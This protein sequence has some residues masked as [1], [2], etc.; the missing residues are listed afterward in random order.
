MSPRN[1]FTLALVALVVFSMAVL[2][3][4]AQEVFS[5]ISGRVVDPSGGVLA[6]V[7][8][9]A[10]NLDTNQETRTAS[11]D[12][13]LYVL[14]N[15]P[16]GRYA[17]AASLSGFK[18]F[19]QEGV[20]LNINQRVT[21]D[22]T[23]P[24]GEVSETITVS[25]DAPL[26]QQEE[27]TISTIFTREKL[28]RLPVTR[29]SAYSLQL[30]APG[31]VSSNQVPLDAD[32]AILVGTTVGNKYNINGARQQSSEVLLDGVSVVHR[33]SGGNGAAV[34]PM[35]D[36]VEE[37][38]IETH[39][40]SAEFGNLG[41]GALQATVRSGTNKFHGTASW[42]H[43]NDNLN[44]RAFNELTKG[45]QKQNVYNGTIG[46][47]ILRNS[48]FFFFSLEGFE[49][50]RQIAR[51]TTVP[52][53][54]Q[55]GGDFSSLVDSR[56]NP[57]RIYDPLTTRTDPATGRVIRDPFPG[58]IIQAS[59]ISPVAKNLLAFYPKPNLSG[60]RNNLAVNGAQATPGK[61]YHFKVDKQITEKNRLFVRYSH[62]EVDRYLASVFPLDN[63]ANTEPLSDYRVRSVAVGDTHFI[64]STLVHDFRFGF[65]RYFLSDGPWPEFFG[66]NWANQ[67]GIKGAGPEIFPRINVSG[68]ESLGLSGFNRD[69]SNSFQIADSLSWVR[70]KHRL[71]G[72]FGLARVQ[73]NSSNKSFPSSSFLFSSLYTNLPGTANTG[74]GLA[75]LLLGL[76]DASIGDSIGTFGQRWWN[77]AYFLQDDLKVSSVFT[78]N[79]GLRLQI[80]GPDR[81]VFNR[82]TNFDSTIRHP[83]AG[84]PGTIL[85]ANESDP[86]FFSSYYGVEPRVGLAW[87]FTPKTVLRSGYGIF[88]MPWSAPF[89][90]RNTGITISRSF[91]SPDN[92]VPGFTFTDTFPSL[93][94]PDV[95]QVSN[96]NVSAVNPN[97]RPGYMQHWN[98][99]IQ[100]ELAKDLMVEASYVGSKGTNLRVA[101]NINQLR[102]ELLGPP[103]QFGGLT[104][105]QR[106]PFPHFLNVSLLDH[107]VDS[108]YHALQTRVEL[109]FA[110]GLGVTGAY[111]FAKAIDDISF[112]DTNGTVQNDFDLTSERSVSGFDTRH[113]LVTNFVYD[114][115]LGRDGRTSSRVVERLV[116]GWQLSGF[117]VAETGRPLAISVSSNLAGSF[118]GQRANIVS[119]DGV[120]PEGQRYEPAPSGIGVRYLNPAAFAHPGEFR[121]GNAPRLSDAFR[122]PGIANFDLALI[123]N[124]SITERAS[125]QFRAESY[126][127]F[128]RVQFGNPITAFGRS[129]FGL[130]T[131]T[132]GPPRVIQFALK[133]MF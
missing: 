126:N 88:T 45:E 85:S 3:P 76:G 101:R 95:T 100:R 124:T 96:I 7:E 40:L 83:V 24:I 20:K 75:G 26:L 54:A 129:D 68:F 37:V 77:T 84:L 21:L 2:C 87:T 80:Q 132:A 43:R 98:L 15:L 70:G 38:K 12:L 55:A 123:K 50:Q 90:Q 23:L 113:R 107:G 74:D 106:R 81:E 89:E 41:G 97:L 94:I 60:D 67:I 30:L 32:R 13:G 33:T 71:K 121:L 47:P 72:G 64:S 9:K 102:P 128:N 104:Q 125:V 18:S 4:Q 59:R 44:A 73:R 46:G 82:Q 69:V 49:D 48:L 130:I 52:T 1:A 127:L 99:G 118:A 119:A 92:I 66:A 56:G 16:P 6:G 17:V 133:F 103:S 10:I 114:L 42:A 27:A 111:A 115:P 116:R 63:P 35:L 19:R 93:T 31:V 34:M 14:L 22:L 62:A 65:T 78:L 112:P 122:R 91:N 25:A 86:T 117:W 57:I 79:L 5:S 58:N 131:G 11:N 53:G 108:N 39:N 109:R 28:E 29:N 105:Q 36:S 120:L 110:G 51:V 8:L 61:Q